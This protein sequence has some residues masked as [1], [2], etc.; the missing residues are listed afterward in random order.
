MLARSLIESS[1]L[2]LRYAATR[3]CRL[4]LGGAAVFRDDTGETAQ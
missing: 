3:N 4:E 2:A 1:P